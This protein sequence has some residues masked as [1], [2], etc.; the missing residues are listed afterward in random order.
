MS[1]TKKKASAARG[2]SRV[3]KASPVKKKRAGARRGRDKNRIVLL[4]PQ[5][6]VVTAGEIAADLWPE[7]RIATVTAGWQEREPE[8]EVLNSVLGGRTDNLR[9]Y[10]RA[11]TAAAADP[12]LQQAHRSLQES[13][14]LLR[15]AYNVRLSKLMDTWTAL[16]VMRGDPA[17]LDPE[18]DAALE[19]VRQLD[20]SHIV[21]IG[22]LRAEFFEQWRPGERDAIVEQRGEIEKQLADASAVAIAGGHIAVLLNRLRIFGL[23]RMLEG[24]PLIAWSAGAMALADTVVLFHDRPPQGPGHAE[25]FDT[26]LGFVSG[27]VPLPDGS[28]RLALDDA[29]RTGRLARRFAPAL[30]VLLDDGSLLERTKGK[31]EAGETTRRITADGATVEVA[32]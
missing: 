14:K 18:R 32:A 19:S 3:K 8:D 31:W 9:L 17:V 25:A 10:G 13:L 15:R 5:S 12:E 6:R 1:P 21:R 7:G 4:G 16:S 20:A 23:D 27:M 11:E 24:T 28:H 26:G 30:C 29:A 22:D 2:A